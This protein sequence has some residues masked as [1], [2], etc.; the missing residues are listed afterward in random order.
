[1]RRPQGDAQFYGLDFR[2]RRS[3][4]L[5]RLVR[6]DLALLDYGNRGVVIG[7]LRRRSLLMTASMSFAFSSGSCSA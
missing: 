3:E 7:R 2:F 5:W 6:L 1:M 4:L